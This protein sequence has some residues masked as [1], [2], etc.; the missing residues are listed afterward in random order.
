MAKNVQDT[1]FEIIKFARQSGLPSL[2]KAQ[3]MEEVKKTPLE[4]YDHESYENDN[5]TKLERK[6]DQALYQLHKNKRIKKRGKGWTINR[7]QQNY[8]PIIC[9]HI[10]QRGDR[11]YCPIKKCYIA[12]PKDQCELLHTS[13][14]T[15]KGWAKGS[16]PMCPGYTN[17]ASTKISKEF[18]KK[19]IDLH[20]DKESKERRYYAR[21]SM[22]PLSKF[23]Q[24]ELA[25]KKKED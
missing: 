14:F 12:S 3:I 22:D 1:V 17:R 16:E 25:K 4:K 7:K 10:E 5:V 9:S 11:Y 8:K 20:D 15:G 19:L 18:S 23:Y 13:V 2:R 24:P 6:I 21:N